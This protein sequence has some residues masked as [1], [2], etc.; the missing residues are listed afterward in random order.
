ML[1][2]RLGENPETVQCRARRDAGDARRWFP[3]RRD[4]PSAVRSVIA[5][6]RAVRGWAFAGYRAFT[7]R[8]LQIRMLQGDPRIDDAHFDPLAIVGRSRAREETDAVFEGQVDGRELHIH[9]CS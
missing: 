1:R 5:T 7:S 2:R 9:R 4:D 3:A 8:Y 6:Q